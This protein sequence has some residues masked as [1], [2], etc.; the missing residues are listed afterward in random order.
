[1]RFGLVPVSGDFTTD[2]LITTDVGTRVSKFQRE[3]VNFFLPY[4]VRINHKGGSL[5]IQEQG[6][7]CGPVTIVKL[8]ETLFRLHVEFD[9][10]FLGPRAKVRIDHDGW[11]TLGSAVA[12]LPLLHGAP[13]DAW[14]PKKN[15]LTDK[16]V[17]AYVNKTLLTS[18]LDGLAFKELTQESNFVAPER[19]HLL[20]W[21]P[22]IVPKKDKVLIAG[23]RKDK[24]NKY[25]ADLHQLFQ[26][27]LTVRMKRAWY[28]PPAVSTP[29]EL[30]RPIKEKTKKKK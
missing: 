13:F 23:I 5:L 20:R 9:V 4:K 7:T 22:K 24:D 29:P 27:R 8:V 10:K 21:G 12:D 2:M 25:M 28:I 14:N 1:M 18:F 30:P 3:G 26:E 6:W 15:G 16:D 11:N 17:L 19:P